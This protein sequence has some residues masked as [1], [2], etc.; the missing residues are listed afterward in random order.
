[1]AHIQKLDLEPKLPHQGGMG[2]QVG[3]SR[4]SREIVARASG[5]VCIGSALKRERG[6]PAISF[7][8]SQ[9]R[10]MAPSSSGYNLAEE[11]PRPESIRIKR[12]PP[13]HQ[14]LSG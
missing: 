11:F 12:S 3:L 14:R 4:R 9:P 5:T 13:S 2:A 1:M 10:K 6:H 8:L 7:R